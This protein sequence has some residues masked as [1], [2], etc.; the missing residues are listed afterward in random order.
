M[1]IAIEFDRGT[2]L[3]RG[4]PEGGALALPLRWDPRVRAH[5]GR[6]RDYRDLLSGL[7]RSS[8]AFEDR[9]PPP[10]IEA[11]RP[12]VWKTLCLRPYQEA[13]LDAWNAAG[14][15]GVVVLPT[16]SGKTRLALS[17][18][19]A[20]G[21]RTLCLVPTRALLEQ[22]HGVV[23][24]EYGGAVGC[25]G[26][27]ER[28]LSPITIATFESAYRYMPRI[29]NR[30]E[31]LVVDEAHHFGGGLRDEALEMATA[32]ARLGLTATPPHLRHHAAGLAELIGPPVF[33]LSVSDLAGSYLAPFDLVKVF[34]ELTPRE[35]RAYEGWVALYREPLDQFRRQ[36][37]AG[38][39][40]SFLREASRSDAGRR[41][42]AAWSRARRLL[43]YPEGKRDLLGSL[44]ERHR[45]SRVMVFVGDNR[46]AYRVAREF[47]IM[48][49]T[50]DIRRRERASVLER[51]RSGELRALVSA[52]VLNEG[53]DVPDAEVG[54][55]VAGGLG[56]REYVQRVGRVLRPP[57]G[58]ARK[59]ALVY[60][61]VVR[62][63]ADV[64]KSARR[65]EGLVGIRAGSL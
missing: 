48:P 1:A 37:R 2:L 63:T 41:A 55:V 42:I 16:G 8:L 23:S 25:L 19:A 18:M 9:V 52:R 7:N 44:L 10:G 5:R 45:A 51:F 27:G 13:A 28:R 30:F 26:D 36:N 6:A 33:E 12:A 56:G 43:A 29:G 11:A 17:A 57:E 53:I 38:S 59:S 31:L 65:V 62:E 34:V 15:R 14:R 40:E 46:T 4:L 21:L 32:P 3:V 64:G 58:N 49:I 20:S 47:L 22:W 39:W 61:L 24:E 54:I 35:R 60:E 50:C